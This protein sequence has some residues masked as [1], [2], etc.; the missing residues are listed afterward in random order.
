M[1]K[2]VLLFVLSLFS[3]SMAANDSFRPHWKYFDEPVKITVRGIEFFIFPNGEF[4]FNAHQRKNHH[5]Y[6]PSDY[7]VRIERDRYGKIRRIGNVFINYNRHRQVSRIG[8]IF[9]KYNHRGLVYK[10]GKL[11]L[12]YAGRRYAVL[13]HHSHFGFWG[14]FYYGPAK[15]PAYVSNHSYDNYPNDRW[16]EDDWENENENYP[17]DSDYYFKTKKNPPKIKTKGRRK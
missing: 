2:L 12:K 15:A 17:G 14:S 13:R 3:M 7:G 1:K 10:I 4:D 11:R 16:D 8:S 9:I 5:Y 6:S